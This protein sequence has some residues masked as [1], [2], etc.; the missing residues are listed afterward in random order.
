MLAHCYTPHCTPGPSPYA[1]KRKVQGSRTKRLAARENEPA[2]KTLALSLSHANACNPL[3]QAHPTCAQGN[4]K[5]AGFPF[6]CFFPLRAPS[7][8]DPSGLGHAATIHSSVQGPSG[9]KTPI[10]SRLFIV[11]HDLCSEF[12]MKMSNYSI[13]TTSKYQF[14]KRASLVTTNL[15]SMPATRTVSFASWLKA[16]TYLTPSRRRTWQ[17]NL[18]QVFEFQVIF[19][20]TICPSLHLHS[21]L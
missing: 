12:N 21:S 20:T 7:R 18:Q 4:T 14:R 15:P 1:Y 3:L 13:E 2:H 16:T 5:A 17:A 8:T 10:T 6:A 11:G 19:S 9:V